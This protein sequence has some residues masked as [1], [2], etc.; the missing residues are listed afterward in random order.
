MKAIILSWFFVAC[1]LLGPGV[2]SPFDLDGDSD[3][4]L[5]DVAV[6]QNGAFVDFDEVTVGME[7]CC[8]NGECGTEIC[9]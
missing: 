5:A 4:D 3:C 2:H 7:F 1:A 8:C 9:P 6:A